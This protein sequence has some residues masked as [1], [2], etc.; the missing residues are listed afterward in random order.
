MW[1]LP[2]ALRVPET[3]P[4]SM[5]MTGVS[6]IIL[7][8]ISGELAALVGLGAAKISW[9]STASHR[10]RGLAIVRKSER[11]DG[12]LAVMPP[13]LYIGHDIQPRGEPMPE[14]HVY[15][16]E[17]RSAEQKKNLMKAISDAV[18]TTIG[19]D[20]NAVTVQI[21]EAPNT[22]KMKGGV[23]FAERATKK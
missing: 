9:R 5:R 12:S 17:G 23:T 1:T 19:T 2:S 4:L 14:V 22:D 7:S 20:I 8:G 11:S 13:R 16:A 21:I 15:L 6:P 18:V 10:R 3:L